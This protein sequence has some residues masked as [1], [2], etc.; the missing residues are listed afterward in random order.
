MLKAGKK[1]KAARKGSIGLNSYT[2]TG[3]EKK[4]V[5]PKTTLTLDSIGCGSVINP[6]LILI[7]DTIPFNYIAEESTTIYYLSFDFIEGLSKT[8]AILR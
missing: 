1:L 3:A 5:D 8:N 6:N 4:N 2:S 7:S